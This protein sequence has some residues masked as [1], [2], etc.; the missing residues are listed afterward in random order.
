QVFSIP[1]PLRITN[2]TN[3]RLSVLPCNNLFPESIPWLVYLFEF[4][5]HHSINCILPQINLCLHMLTPSIPMLFSQ[6]HT[7]PIQLSI[8]RST[9]FTQ[10]LDDHIQITV[11]SS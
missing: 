11:N 5:V 10:P 3:N 9:S 1:S 2:L 8:P 6:F 4:T 7:L